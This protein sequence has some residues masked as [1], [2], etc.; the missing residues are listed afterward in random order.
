MN[1][2]EQTANR[3][4]NDRKHRIKEEFAALPLDKKLSSLFEMEVV[5][6]NESISYVVNNSGEIFNKVGDVI[7]DFGTR[8]ECEFKKATHKADAPGAENA[9]EPVTEP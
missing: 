7:N 5:A 2:Q 8:V 6:L 3:G 1:N 4:T 9:T